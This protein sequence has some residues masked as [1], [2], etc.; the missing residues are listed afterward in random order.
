MNKISEKFSIKPVFNFIKNLFTKKIQ[1][2]VSSQIQKAVK[3][4][5]TESTDS[6]VESRELSTQNL[7]FDEPDV[8]EVFDDMNSFREFLKV[9][10]ENSELISINDELK[11]FLE[12]VQ[13][14]FELYPDSRLKLVVNELATLIEKNAKKIQEYQDSIDEQ[15]QFLVRINTKSPNFGAK[16]RQREAQR[17]ERRKQKQEAKDNFLSFH[18]RPINYTEHSKILKALIHEVTNYGK[19]IIVDGEGSHDNYKFIF[20]GIDYRICSQSKSSLR[21]GTVSKAKLVANIKQS[22]AY[23]EGIIKN[24]HIHIA[25]NSV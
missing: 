25:I 24:K 9:C 20:N 22:N 15:N 13:I 6:S 16:K 23:L 14:V 19:L 4:Q 17:L 7:I 10:N 1:A 2:E 21:D 11:E 18:D 12:H 5:D 3:V 8:H